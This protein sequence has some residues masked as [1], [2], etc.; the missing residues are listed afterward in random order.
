MVEKLGLNRKVSPS[1]APS[2]VSDLTT[3]M[4]NNTSRTGIR[5]LA[6]FSI[7]FFTPEITMKPVKNII[8]AN[9]IRGLHKPPVK[10]S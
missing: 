4:S 3:R 1:F 5:I 9:Q 7:P 10:A 8:T 6:Y 2:R